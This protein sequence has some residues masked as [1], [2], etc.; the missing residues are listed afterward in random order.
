MP[1]Y[2]KQTLVALVLILCFGGSMNNQLCP[3][4]PTLIDPDSVELHCYLFIIRMD[5]C[6]GS[7]NTLGDP[8]GRMCVPNEIE[9]LT[10][11]YFI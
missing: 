4:R 5:R 7:S 9:D 3:V 6:D 10:W 2:I 1:R 11:K 8:F